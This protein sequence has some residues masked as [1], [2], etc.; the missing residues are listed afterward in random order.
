[1]PQFPADSHI[2][3]FLHHT[4]IECDIITDEQLHQVQ[5]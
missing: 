3:S 1:M 5:L 4:G 2:V